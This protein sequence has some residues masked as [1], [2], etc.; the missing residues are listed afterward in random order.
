MTNQ[1]KDSYAMEIAA[2]SHICLYSLRD[3]MATNQNDPTICIC[4]TKGNEQLI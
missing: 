3:R 2:V 4:F 1:Q